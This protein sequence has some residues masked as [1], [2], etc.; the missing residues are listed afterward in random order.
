MSYYGFET[1]LFQIM[2]DGRTVFFPFGRL[3]RGYE[4]D[5]GPDGERLRRGYSAW[6][7]ACIIMVAAAVPWAGYLGAL[8]AGLMWVVL[9]TAWA[10]YAVRRLKPSD[11]KFPFRD[12]FIRRSRAINP[13]WLWAAEIVAIPLAIFAIFDLFWDPENWFRAIYMIV[14]FSLLAIGCGYMLVMRRET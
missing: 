1:G 8:A 3:G 13:I 2:A 7:V 10:F 4:L 11:E 6:Y 12:N 14:V 9:Y 5:P